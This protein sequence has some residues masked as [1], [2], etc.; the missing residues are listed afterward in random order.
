MN[1]ELNRLRA[2]MAAVRAQAEAARQAVEDVELAVAGHLHPQYVRKQPEEL[3]HPF[4]CTVTDNGSS[5]TVGDGLIE[6]GSHIFLLNQGEAKAEWPTFFL[7]STPSWISVTYYAPGSNVFDVSGLGTSA[8]EHIGFKIRVDPA[9]GHFNSTGSYFP[10]LIREW[11]LWAG[12]DTSF[13]FIR[14]CTFSTLN[15]KVFGPLKQR[16]RSDIS[17]HTFQADGTGYFPAGWNCALSQ[18]Q[19]KG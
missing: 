12:A 10:T 8:G 7:D 11:G 6:C 2:E 13:Q 3:W 18:G 19:T 1:D 15:G 9:T 5:I 17:L 16:L 4:K 14:V